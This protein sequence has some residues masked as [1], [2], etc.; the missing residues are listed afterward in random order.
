MYLRTLRLRH[1]WTQKELAK[2]TKPH[3]AQNTISKLERRAHIRPAHTTVVALARAFSIDPE[4]IRF[5]I[6]PRSRAG[7]TKQHDARRGP[8]VERRPDASEATP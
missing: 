6:D 3:V 7:R 5:G 8:R 2:R 1:G 4:S